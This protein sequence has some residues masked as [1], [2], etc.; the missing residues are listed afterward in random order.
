MAQLKRIDMKR[1]MQSLI[2]KSLLSMYEGKYCGKKQMKLEFKRYA[3]GGFLAKLDNYTFGVMINIYQDGEVSYQTHFST[4]PNERIICLPA[5]ETY[6]EYEV[7][8]AFQDMITEIKAEV[9]D[10]FG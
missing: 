10:I 3:N 8:S 5:S 7:E 9:K 6:N 4:M 1:K 2:T